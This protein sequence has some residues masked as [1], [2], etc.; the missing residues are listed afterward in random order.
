MQ[1]AELEGSQLNLHQVRNCRWS[2][3]E[4]YDIR[5]ETRRYDLDHLV[6]GDLLLSYWIG[7]AIAHTLVSFGFADRRQLVFS[8]EI[9]KERHEAFSAVAE[10]LRQYEA[11]LV[12]AADTE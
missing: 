8:L 7:P 1:E 12:A 5:W 3:P 9:R 2:S 6:S 10:F 11:I 4:D